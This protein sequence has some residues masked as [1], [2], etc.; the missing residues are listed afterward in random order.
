MKHASIRYLTKEGFRNIWSNRLMSLAS[1]SVLSACLVLLGCSFMLF[2]NIDAVLGRIEAQNVIMVF[3]KDDAT[4]AELDELKNAIDSTPNV[5]Y[6]EFIP[7][8]QAY[9]E[10]LESLGEDAS[11]LEGLGN[12]ILPD[13][14]RVTVSDMNQY[15]NTVEALSSLDNILRIRRNS[16]LATRLIGMRTSIVY[17]GA[18]IIIMLLFVAL[19]IIAN[20]V[21]ITMFTRRLEIS[22]MKAVGATNSFIRWPFMVEGILLGIISASLSVGLVFLI[23]RL[24]ATH[25]QNL[26]GILG[27][28]LVPFGEYAVMLYLG[29]LAVGILTGF[30]GSLVSL[31]KYLREQG[32]VVKDE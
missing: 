26:I 4:D 25:I 23:Y 11:L 15:D 2:A 5:A 8:E 32:S 24:A 13:A 22:I 21:R 16:D 30:F 19:F 3:A 29:F 14:F 27:A 31:G 6:S 18:G 28:T 12:D 20:T 7:K 10:L 1:V 17:I 9:Q